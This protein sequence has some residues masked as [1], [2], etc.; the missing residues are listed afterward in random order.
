MIS[1][2]FFSLIRRT[3]AAPMGPTPNCTAR[4]FFFKA[5]SVERAARFLDRSFSPTSPAAVRSSQIWSEY[6][7]ANARR[8]QPDS[9]STGTLACAGFAIANRARTWENGENR[10][11]KSACATKSGSHLTLSEGVK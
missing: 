11:G 9:S 10:T 1:I 4:I 2:E 7:K 3:M 6:D 5:C 8:V